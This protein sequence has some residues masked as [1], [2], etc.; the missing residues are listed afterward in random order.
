MFQHYSMSIYLK[1]F[2]IIMCPYTL[3]LYNKSIGPPEMEDEEHRNVGGEKYN[4]RNEMKYRD[5]T[6]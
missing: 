1:L 3:I 5:E 4:E 6:K 2:P